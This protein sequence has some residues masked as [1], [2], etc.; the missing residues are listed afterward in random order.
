MDIASL[1][2]ALESVK[3]LSGIAKST[4]NA[5]VDHQLKDKLIEIQ[6]GV[7]DVQAQLISATAERLELL[8]QISALTLRIEELQENKL[9]LSRYKLSEI[10]TGKFLYKSTIDSEDQPP[11]YA[12]PACYDAGRVRILQAAKTGAL[13]TRFKCMASDC[14]FDIY[15]GP[16]D[17]EKPQRVA[18]ATMKVGW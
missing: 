2:T 15:V 18:P 7:L 4:A 13:Q 10:E 14:T 6:Q 17:P 1:A 12:C 8:Q 11:H 3:T 9:K 5:I 16:T